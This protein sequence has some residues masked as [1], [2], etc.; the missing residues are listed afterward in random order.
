MLL[1]AVAVIAVGAA[2]C[3]EEGDIEVRSLSFDGNRA[4]SDSQLRAV[5][6]TRTS[7]F[8]P[9]SRRRYFNRNVFEQDLERLRRFYLDRGFPS[10]RVVSTDVNL[11]DTNGSV[12]LR[13][14]I[15]E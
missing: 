13:I 8:F 2:G 9:W 15:D 1:A 5:V 3:H 11:N 4:F 7:G 12:R 14:A 6:A 10:A